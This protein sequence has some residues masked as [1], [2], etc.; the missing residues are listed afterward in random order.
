MKVRVHVFGGVSQEMPGGPGS[1]REIELPAEA[2]VEDLLTRLQIEAGQRVLAV[3]GGRIL[4]DT[5]PL[6]PWTE[7]SLLPPAFGG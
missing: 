2:R 3:A 4:A 6:S 1:L 7:I 5:D